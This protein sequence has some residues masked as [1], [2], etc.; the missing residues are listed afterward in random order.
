MTPEPQKNKCQLNMNL[1]S[2]CGPEP[3]RSVIGFL[4]QVSS[5]SYMPVD[6]QLSSN[7]FAF[8]GQEDGS[9]EL[10]SSAERR[11]KRSPSVSEKSIDE[12]FIRYHEELILACRRNRFDRRRDGEQLPDLELLADLQHHR[13]ATC[14][15]DFTRS[16]LV[17]LWFACENTG[18]DGK[19][20]VV[21]IDSGEQFLQISPTDIEGKTISEILNFETRSIDGRHIGD[22]LHTPNEEPI[23]SGPKFWH[24][25]PASL[26]ERIP[27]QHSLFVFA[28]LS[29]GKPNTVEI[30]VE[31][32]SKELIREDLEKLYDIHEESLFP[33]FIGFAY[34]QRHDASYGRSPADYYRLGINA[35][36]RGEY[37]EAIQYLSNSIQLNPNSFRAYRF[38]SDA[39]A[40]IGEDDKAVGDHSKMLELIPEAQFVYRH[41]GSAYERLGKF[42]SAIRDFSKL[43]ELDPGEAMW[44]AA[45]GDVYRS[46]NDFDNAFRDYS[47]AIELNPKEIRAYQRRATA[48]SLLSNWDDAIRDYSR[49]IDLD[50]DDPFVYI[51][52]GGAYQNLDGLDSAVCDY[53]KVIELDPTELQAFD[54]RGLAF[55]RLGEFDSAVRDYTTLIQ[56]DPENIWVYRSRG[57]VYLDIGEFDSAVRDFTMM[58]ELDSEEALAYI[59]LGQALEGLGKLDS[60]VRS[61]SKGI[62][63][64]PESAS[65]FV[66]RAAAHLHLRK[67]KQARSDFDAAMALEPDALS[68][69]HMEYGPVADFQMK[70]GIQLPEDI[71][72]LISP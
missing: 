5:L 22:S 61:Y 57:G 3:V 23:E 13:A 18:K 69:F 29:S 44:Y 72:A 17:A 11:L 66:R 32:T 50:P 58:I 38:R 43:I 59:L 46:W 33:D 30:L 41:R 24:W 68:N 10:E 36:Q 35:M 25:S 34:M 4:Q 45:R 12:V 28:P 20:F 6:G 1:D 19:V 42:D 15:I 9:W 51:M 7:V 62:E 21:N 37:L 71:V 40:M 47:K 65:W 53:S 60:A 27:A 67:W 26:N 52:R 64:E 39:Y 8:R 55:E 2:E 16:A 31:S 48:Y 70:V 56:R 14:L 54:L 49:M 63:L